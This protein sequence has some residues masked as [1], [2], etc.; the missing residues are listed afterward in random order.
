MRDAIEVIP[1]S[2]KGTRKKA[3]SFS[4]LTAQ[5]YPQPQTT[6]LERRERHRLPTISSRDIRITSGASS[7]KNSLSWWYVFCLAKPSTAAHP[8][9]KCRQTSPGRQKILESIVA[10]ISCPSASPRCNSR[11]PCT[12]RSRLWCMW[13]TFTRLAVSVSGAFPRVFEVLF[14]GGR[15]LGGWLCTTICILPPRLA[16]RTPIGKPGENGKEGWG[17]VGGLCTHIHSRNKELITVFDFPGYKVEC[18]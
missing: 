7:A 18:V 15:G 16:E 4:T 11:S 17:G 6:T 10:Y 14:T 1:V 9:H 5:T 3:V 8:R 2:G 13:S 12:R